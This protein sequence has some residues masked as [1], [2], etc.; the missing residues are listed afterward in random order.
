MASPQHRLSRW[1][2]SRRTGGPLSQHGCAP[3]SGIRKFDASR[4]GKPSPPRHMYSLQSPPQPFHPPRRRAISAVAAALVLIAPLVAVGAEDGAA[5]QTGTF[6]PIWANVSQEPGGC[7]GPLTTGFSDSGGICGWN[8]STG[9]VDYMY[10]D[11]GGTISYSFTVPAGG[12]ETLTYGIPAGGYLNNAAATVS[13]DGGPSTTI[14]SDL[15]PRVTR[16]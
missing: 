8:A 16:L 11:A 2:H 3:G 13:V 15:D 6:T 5:A 4:T 14:S 7:A 12:S 1:W 10:I 9:V